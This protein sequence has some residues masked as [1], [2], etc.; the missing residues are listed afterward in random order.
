[1]GRKSKTKEEKTAK[2]TISLSREAE[3]ILVEKKVNRSKV[4]SQLIIQN[5]ASL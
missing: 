3:A 2:I 1:M 4:I 5:A